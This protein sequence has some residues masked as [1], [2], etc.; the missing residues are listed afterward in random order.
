[1]TMITHDRA[2]IR[3]L[4]AH[5]IVSSIMHRVRAYR[6]SRR[7]L[8]ELSAMEDHILQDIGLA[9]TDIVQASVAELGTDRIDMLDRARTRRMR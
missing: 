7:L 5:G 2:Q 6:E 9:R 3:T 8:G 4:A 1:M